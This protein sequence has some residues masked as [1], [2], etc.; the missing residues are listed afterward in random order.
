[1]QSERLFKEAPVWQ[2]VGTL[3]GPSVLSVLVMVI[4]NMTDLFFIGLLKDTAQ[5]AAV[6][7]VGPVFTL[8]SAGA[9]VLGMGGCAV[10]ANSLGA[11]DRQDAR[12]V[13]SLCGWCALLTGAFLAVVLNLFC[14]PILY[15]LGTNAEILPY[16]THYLRILALGA[17]AMI[18][19][20]SAASLLRADGAIRRGLAGNLAGSITNIL[21]DPLFILIFGWNIAGAA[22]ATMLGNLVASGI[23]LH[24]ILRRSEVLSLSPSHALHHSARLGRVLALGLPNGVSSLLSG[25]AGSFSN[26]LL[27]AYGTNAL[28]AMA[29]AD[30]SAMVVTLIQMGICM[31]LQPLLAYNVGGHNLP[32]L[33]AVLSRAFCLTAGFGTAFAL[34]CPLAQRPLIGLFLSDPGAISLARHLYPWLLAGSPLLGLYYLSINFLQATGY[35]GS[36]TL[37]SALRQ[38]VLLVPALYGFHSLLGLPGLAAAR[39]A[40]DLFSAVIA[41][42]LFLLVWRRLTSKVQRGRCAL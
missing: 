28:A 26:R 37:L 34:V 6:A 40:T 4:Y 30:K 41:L 15:M 31:G 23:Y 12:C 11:G 16:A 7:V 33:R 35:A 13:S 32:R 39:A 2:A 18:F 20:V 27:A 14:E 10:V 5:T 8:A 9:T 24:H 38:G 22:A 29:A 42:L 36:A 25:L 1:M 17:P 3:V 21:L 19:S